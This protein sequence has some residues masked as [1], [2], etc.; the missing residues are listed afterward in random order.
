MV[1]AVSITLSQLS[2]FLTVARNGSVK[3]AA[4]QLHVTQPSVSAALS[5]L[6]KEVGVPLTER[7]GRTIRL[8]AAGEAL[9]PYARDVLGLLEQGQR[10]ARES[11]DT[12]ARE[13]RVA[14][15]TTAAEYL[16][17]PLMR[18]FSTLHPEIALTLEVGNR[19][20]VLQLLLDHD[21]DVAIGGAPPED[22]RVS[23]RPFLR[24]EIVLIV[25]ADDEL[26]R[27][28]S[29]TFAGLAERTWLLRERGSGTRTL[30]E[31]LL[32]QHG[33]KP[34]T[35]TLG[36]N[37]AIKQAVRMGLGVSL[38][39]R[40]AVELELR[41]GVLATAPLRGLP[42]RHWSA[43]T[44]ATATLRPAVAEFVDFL[45]S[46][47]APAAIAEAAAGGPS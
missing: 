12:V 47:S 17:P 29:V 19:E 33:A 1:R 14:A 22:G 34:H 28:R 32:V 3:R 7:V 25:A 18:R 43:L 46:A 37:G 2:T 31:G 30:V 26:A 44:Q 40:A 8:T 11:A 41:T 6:A 21:A 16:V 27:L 38:Q 20:R 5:A 4:E 45:A 36:S 23:G 42:V 9:V 10:A 24:N 35:L 13:V 15:V 39:S